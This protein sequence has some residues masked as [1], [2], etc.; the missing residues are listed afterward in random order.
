MNEFMIH[1]EEIV[2]PVRAFASRK[3]R[4]RQELLAHL[5]AAFDEE[6]AAGGDEATALQRAKTR[7]GEPATLTR[8]LQESVPRIERTL[9]AR[10]PIPRALERWEL[11]SVSWRKDCPLTPMQATVLMAGTTMLPFAGV[12]SL[13][14]RIN[15]D[16][17]A[18][19][20]LMFERPHTWFMMNLASFILAFG[21][22]AICERFIVAVASL[23]NALRS[24]R[25]RAYAAGIVSLPALSIVLLLACVNRRPASGRELV[26]SFIF[27]G[28]LLASQILV[29]RLIR[30]LR[31]PYAE[32]LM[33]DIAG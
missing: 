4:M 31:R 25:V 2:R 16:R 29:G 15:L 3:L 14:L 28:V 33:L 30:I 13:A 23:K 27:G 11:R 24:L 26:L 32:W 20:R 1:V 17:P 10:L 9:M 21:S 8:T 6:R 19:Q 18:A 7:L 5:R 22:F 12:V